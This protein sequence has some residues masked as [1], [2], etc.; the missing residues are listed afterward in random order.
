MKERTKIGMILDESFP[1]DPRVMNECKLLINEGYQVFLF[2]LD[3]G[4][5]CAVEWMGEK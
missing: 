5:C 1:P 2:C 3:Y 4:R